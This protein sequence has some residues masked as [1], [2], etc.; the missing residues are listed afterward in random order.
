MFMLGLKWLTPGYIEQ[1]WNL[2]ALSGGLI[3]G[4]PLEELLF[5]FSFGLYWTGVYEHFTWSNRVAHAED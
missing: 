2:P 4:I 1:V 3:Y 5:G